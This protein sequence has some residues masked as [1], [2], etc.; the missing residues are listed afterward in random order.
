MPTPTITHTPGPDGYQ[1]HMHRTGGKRIRDRL[2]RLYP[3]LK[4]ATERLNT[5]APGLLSVMKR[6]LCAVDDMHKRC[7]RRAGILFETFDWNLCRD[8]IVKAEGGG[9]NERRR[10]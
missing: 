5:A 6:V 7:P 8:E 3:E 9:R 2:E 1:R 4:V 10:V